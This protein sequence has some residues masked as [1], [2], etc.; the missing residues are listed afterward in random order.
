MDLFKD[1]LKSLKTSRISEITES[2]YRNKLQDLLE[3]VAK[4][5]NPKI[6]IIH[7]P[8]REGRFGS[9]DYKVTI[10][11][12]I[13]GYVE[14]K[15]IGEDL[16]RVLKSE[17]IEKYK[18]LSDNLILTNYIEFI[19]LK[20]GR[21]NKRENLSYLTDFENKKET[22]NSSREKAVRDLIL[23]FFS[24]APKG[25]SSSKKL[26]EALSV[27]AK[28]LKNFL[29]EE[30]KRQEKEHTEG[31]LYGL[32]QTFKKYVFTE[33]LI[34]EF[35]DTFAQNLVYGLFLAKLSADTDNINLYNAKK[36]ISGSFELIKELIG[37][38]DELDKEEYLEIRWVVEEVLTVLNSLDLVSIKRSLSF[39]KTKEEENDHLERDPYIYFYEDFLGM[40][41]KKLKKAK[42]VYY[43]P[44][45]IVSFIIRSIDKFLQK[46][47]YLEKGLAEHNRVTLLDFATGTGTFLLETFKIIFEK[48]PEE[49]GKRDLII[50]DHILKNIYGFEYMIAPYTIAHLKL[51]E[52]LKSKNYQLSNK[53]RFQIF[54]TNTLE[55]INKQIQIPILPAL[56]NETIESQKIKDKPILVIVGNPPYLGH[57]KNNGEWINRNIKDYYSINGELIKEKN[58]KWL[59]D[60]YVKFFRFAQYKIDQIE[61]GI[62]GIITNHSFIDNPTFRGMRKS[63][64]KTFDQIF[65]LDLHGNKY[66]KEKTP[67]GGKDENVFDKIK[68][69]V[70]I[71]I[72]IK[73]KNLEKKIY[74]ADFWGLRSEKY[75]RCLLSNIETIEWK[76]FIP[77]EPFYLF[78]FQE[79]ITKKEYKKGYSLNDIFNISGN[80]IVTKRDK[81]VISFDKITLLNN[82]KKF[83]NTNYNDNEIASIFNL[84]TIDKDKW[85]L[86][87]ARKHI[88]ENGIN[89]NKIIKFLYRP[90]DQRY[91]YY[92]DILV[93]RL[94]EKI[95]KNMGKENLALIVGRY[96]SAVSQEFMWNIAFIS[97]TVTD[98][99]L[100]YRGGAKVYPLYIYEDIEGILYSDE[101]NKYENFNIEFKEYLNKFYSDSC[102]P[103]Q[104]FS[105]IY[106]LLYS[107]SYRVK[108]H[109]FLNVDF[110]NILFPKSK[111]VFEKMSNLGKDLINVQ[112]FKFFPSYKIGNFLEKGDNIVKDLKFI[113]NKLF[114][115]ESQYFNLVSDDIYKFFIGGYQVIDKYLKYRK[116]K[117][118]TLEEIENVENIIKVIAFTIDQMKK[119]DNLTKDWI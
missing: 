115:N 118:L 10:A 114:I 62:V 58:T 46:Y 111:E 86:S 119:I 22:I 35:S 92:D 67:E 55:P 116:G 32:Y 53:E 102:S 84:P 39:K 48:I 99:N 74:H 90:F 60:D 47:F 36:Y 13:I 8:K 110:P 52:Y 20:D 17:Q 30:L 42:G 105:Y 3:S 54:L 68:Q 11:D 112:L 106:S 73:N 1:Y 28:L 75:K 7:E 109:D 56:T 69:G 88:I 59:K 71:S 94:V 43:T 97:D 26:A 81:L 15:T 70:A 96:G 117:Q 21:V 37:F 2:T 83:G 61:N 79:S 12:N 107:P 49:S 91:L 82:L 6:K 57:S 27:R 5:I 89:E 38:L 50:S 63:L 34:E 77:S 66:K 19:W 113:N 24:Q 93:A 29:F 103:E 101:N 18:R 104:I 33:L 31:K 78:K 40:Y 51:S 23:N 45:Q 25:I 87:E 108:Y 80:G 65:I 98:L 100:F 9:P 64:L 95:S 44:S 85:N 14:N 16:D 41:D 72:L 76:E 4:E